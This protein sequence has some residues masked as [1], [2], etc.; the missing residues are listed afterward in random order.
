MEEYDFE[1][2]RKIEESKIIESYNEGINSVISL[3]K[4]MSSQIDLLTN[5]TYGL[6]GKISGLNSDISTLSEEMGELK[7]TSKRQ[8]LRILELEA[9]LNKNSSNSG[10]PPSSD[11][12]KKSIKNNRKKS[13]RSSGGQ[14]GHRGNT[15]NKVE[16]PDIVVEYKT[17]C[18]CDCGHNL[19]NVESTKKTRQVFDIPK[20]QPIVT[21]YVSNEK[22]CPG[23][24]KVHITEFPPKVT[25]PVQYGE[26]ILALMTYLTQYQLLPLKRAT[27]TIF[28]ITGLIVSEGTLVNAAH[29]LYK[30]LESAVEGIKGQITNSNVTHFDETGMRSEGKTK[31]MHVASTESLTYY[32]V[33]D[34][35]GEKAA[36]D[37]GILPDFKGT[38]VH[39]HWK[40]YYRFT[41]CMHSECNSH[42]LRALQDVADNYHQDWAGN[43]GSTLLEIYSR[44]EDL[45]ECGVIEMPALEIEQWNMRYHKIIEEGIKEDADKSPVVLNRWDKPKKSKPL[46]L[47]LKLQQYDIE[48]LAFM[49]DFEIPFTNNLA[50]R[51]LRMQKLRQKISGCFRG[52]N[53]ANEFCRIRSYISTARKNGKDAMDAIASAIKGQPFI[54]E[55]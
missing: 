47:L 13:G 36:L 33:H 39:D 21:E 41:D 3:V 52:K 18:E 19:E 25:Q 35:R 4:D 11:G 2:V 27:E 51:D 1:A 15:L 53:G 50:E 14:P 48:T 43:M 7:A 42:H 10:K 22:V 26:N 28:S 12:L 20:P 44:V 55:A 31:W 23:C 16:K 9:M 45:K 5:N 46:Q 32:E 6:N 54:P 30:K 29:A 17:P 8:E 38:A 34:K 40:P 24:G 49:Y 37:I